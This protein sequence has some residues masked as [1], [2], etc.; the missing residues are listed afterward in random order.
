MDKCCPYVVAKRNLADYKT[1]YSWQGLDPVNTNMTLKPKTRT[2]TLHWALCVA[3]LS[4]DGKNLGPW[5][6]I[7]GWGIARF[8]GVPRYRGTKKPPKV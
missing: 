2:P 7:P 1:N 5:N 3:S 4:E 8:R 6:G